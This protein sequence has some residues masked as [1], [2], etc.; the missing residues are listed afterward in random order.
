MTANEV[1]MQDSEELEGR[2]DHQMMASGDGVIG[3][4]KINNISFHDSES[5]VTALK[6]TDFDA[7][8]M[9]CAMLTR[10]ADSDAF[11]KH[12]LITD[13]DLTFQ[14]KLTISSELLDGK[15]SV[16]LSRYGKYLIEDDLAY[17]NKLRGDYMIDFHLDSL[18][19]RFHAAAEKSK[20]KVK[21]RRFEAMQRLILEGEYFS[22]EEMK[23]RDPLLFEEMIG[24][25]QT[26]EDVAEAV[27]TADLS[28]SE[29]LLRHLQAVQNN[30]LYE[31][32]QQ[33]SRIIQASTEEFDSEDE[34]DDNEMDEEKECEKDDEEKLVLKNE[35]VEIM[36]QRF[37]N[38]EDMEFDY[39]KVDNNEDFDSLEMVNRD[40]EDRYFADS[41][42]CDFREDDDDDS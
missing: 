12:Q 26:N 3:S 7:D 34:D 32:Q 22:V 28:L 14:E 21:N 33:Q 15:P 1:S 11:F 41:P 6:L 27:A 29:V 36:Q 31:Q 9:R 39:H 5:K 24:K 17:F 25:Y 40:E 37:L 13:P 20:K 30:E 4:D 10:V 2:D 23:R 18:S 16:F 35:F 42:D 38:G 8:E 19:Q